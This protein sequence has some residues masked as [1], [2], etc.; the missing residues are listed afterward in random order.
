MHAYLLTN[1]GNK[2][3]EHQAALLTFSFG[4]NAVSR[5]LHLANSLSI[6]ATYRMQT[7]CALGVVCHIYAKQELQLMTEIKFLLKVF[8]CYAPPIGRGH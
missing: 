1:K 3:S 7:S 5:L 2:Q 8:S 4:S 6:L